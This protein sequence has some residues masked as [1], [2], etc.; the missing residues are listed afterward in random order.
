MSATAPEKKALDPTL[1]V[2]RAAGP[3]PFEVRDASGPNIGT[4]VGQF[5]KYN[6]W[7]EINSFFEG[8]F[9]ERLAPGSG[10]KTIRENRENIKVLFQHGHDPQIGD[11]PLGP[12]DSL[13][14]TPTG[15]EYEVSLIDTSYNRDLVPGLRAGLYGASF[16]FKVMR[17]DIVEEP[18]RSA[19]NPDGIPERT[20]KEYKLME[21]GPVTFP[22]YP[23]ATAGM[24]SMTD[25]LLFGWLA[26]HPTEARDMLTVERALPIAAAVERM[27]S[28]DFGTLAQMSVL[29]VQYIDEQDEPDEHANVVAMEGVLVQLHDLQHIETMEEEPAEDEGG[30][31]MKHATEPDGVT[32]DVASESD[33]PS[34]DDAESAAHSAAERGSAEPEPHLPDESREDAG[35]T[36]PGSDPI[37]G[38]SQKEAKKP[39]L[40]GPSRSTRRSS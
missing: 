25:D 28:E 30:G 34:E 37:Y 22:A 16:R 5:T 4:L 1:S 18:E 6:E 39:W 38:M 31:M 9:L 2:V 10:A 20:I 32:R 15:P 21:F 19:E 40:L 23:N 8:R 27:D 17:E 29:G 24:R 26:Q 35:R 7:T 36:R 14:E 12:I 11:K 33:A 13:K 3:V